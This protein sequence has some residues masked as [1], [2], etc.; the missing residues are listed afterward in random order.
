MQQSSN[1]RRSL[2]SAAI[3]AALLPASGLALA[4]AGSQQPEAIGL[5]RLSVTGTRIAREAFVTP[6]PVTA[7]PAEE[8]RATGAV[9]I[10]DLMTKMPALTPAYT[11]GNSTRFIGT[12]G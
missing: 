7:I 11:L 3:V 12:A 4:Q 10:G 1:S 6:S 9:T 2:R 5:V 8:I